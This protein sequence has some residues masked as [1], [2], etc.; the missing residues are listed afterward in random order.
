MTSKWPELVTL[1]VTN[2]GKLTA[3]AVVIN[4]ALIRPTLRE[5]A[6]MVAALLFAGAQAVES[7]LLNLLRSL[8]G[9][10]DT[11]S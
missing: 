3:V 2:L 8:L 4:E 6:L 10:G 5:A 9:S 1:L 7:A 11:K